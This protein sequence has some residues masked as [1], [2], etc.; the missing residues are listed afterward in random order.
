MFRKFFLS[1]NMRI[2]RYLFDLAE[3][4]VSFEIADP[5]ELK[6]LNQEKKVITYLSNRT[7]IIE[8][9]LLN[10]YFIK[11]G[12]K[13]PS[14]SFGPVTVLFF[15]VRELLSLIRSAIT[16]KSLRYSGKITGLY[17]PLEDQEFFVKNPAWAGFIP[18]FPGN[19]FY[20]VPVTMLWDKDVN[21]RKD[22]SVYWLLPII[23]RYNLWPTFTELFLFIIGRRKLTVRIGLSKKIE[24]DKY[25][26]HLFEKLYKIL[27]DEK[28]NV[29]G[30]SL[31]N[32]LEI[33]N[34]TL[35]D[36]QVDSNFDKETA[37][38]YIEEIITH[39]SPSDTDRIARIINKILNSLFSK[40]IYSKDEIKKLRRLAAIPNINI[41]F[42]PTHKS[43]LDYL[44]LFN[45]LYSEKITVPLVAAGDNLNFFPLGPILRRLG[46]FFI[47]RKMK[48]DALYQ[49]VFKTY[50][51]KIIESGYNIEFFI[52]GGRTRSGRVRAARTGLINMLSEIKRKTRRRIYIVPVS[53]TYEKLREIQEYKKEQA[54][55]KTPEKTG[56]LPRMLSLF[57]MH[58][59]QAYLTFGNAVYLKG[60]VTDDFSKEIAYILEK[61]SFLSFS[62]LF[63][64][65]FLSEPE[66][67]G[68]TMIK[69]MEHIL[70]LLSR[71]K[72]LRIARPLFSLDTNV[73]RLIERMCNSGQIA[74]VKGKKNFYR[75]KEDA[76]EEFTFYKNNGSFIFAPFFFSAV[77]QLDTMPE[78][79]DFAAD[80]LESII[81][82]FKKS[83]SYKEYIKPEDIP[84]WLTSLLC[85]FFL[86]YFEH[87]E[88]IINI[89]KER[90]PEPAADGPETRGDIIVYI[91]S[92]LSR[93]KITAHDEEIY[94][95][96]LF[97]EKFEIINNL[98]AINQEIIDTVSVKI[99]S[100][101]SFL[102]KG[103]AG[104]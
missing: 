4:H 5:D 49:L 90:K 42:I 88:Q 7:S 97:L 92:C 56:F 33:K 74:E 34:E 19:Q 98:F 94:E 78:V 72:T 22:S 8:Q 31:K 55:G 60:N 82:G 85:L 13:L 103:G 69:R 71:I 81:Q 83:D 99:G 17:I 29:V 3:K 26:Q 76:K 43:Y 32:W 67:N 53:I 30:A 40:I 93:K 9:F 101:L 44:I 58:Y 70:S 11:H 91:S 73:P 24:I 54:E 65:L 12:F 50:L 77:S 86:S 1:F 46:A 104:Q 48:D 52:E 2:F 57:R 35:M 62:S 39:Y 36:L 64:T 47:R 18:K 68:L 28:Q 45:M 89:L 100:L 14:H 16:R 84:P 25:S 51:Q 15:S 87:L 66:I 63:A 23:G 96:V 10:G 38:D 61:Q 37:E 20:A 27:K 59:G 102:R 80:Y 95:T 41:V 21:K 75:L 79:R 6:R